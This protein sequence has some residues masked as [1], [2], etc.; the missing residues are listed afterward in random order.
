MAS[1]ISRKKELNP[2]HSE[3]Y[4]RVNS[5]ARKGRK[6]HKKLVLQKILLQIPR[7]LSISFYRT[8][9][10]AIFS[11]AERFGTEFWEFSV[12]RNGSEQ[13]SERLLLFCSMVQ[14]SEKFPLWGTFP[15]RILRVFCSAEQPEFRRN[16][17]IVPSIPP[18]AEQFFCQI[19]PTLCRP[20]TP[21]LHVHSALMKPPTEP[22]ARQ[23]SIIQIFMIF[24]NSSFIRVLKVL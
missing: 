2:K 8:E 12:P 1:V 11:T 10:Q 15:N 7:V 5:E 13:N 20:L 3:V 23:G 24:R 17:P 9:F 21:I 18:S 4:G 6:W 19:F 14:N 16:K 22:E